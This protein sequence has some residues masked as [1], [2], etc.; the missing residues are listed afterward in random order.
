MSLRTF[1]YGGGHQ[2]TAGLILAA[3]GKIDYPVFLFANVG[4]DSEHPAT[5]DFVHNVA[6]PYAAA[7]GIELHE[8]HRERR[9]GSR[10]TLH[11]RPMPRKSACY[12]CPFHT[13]GTW[14]EMRRTEPDLFDKTV[15]LETLLNDRRA[16]LG[17]DSVYFNSR[18]VP[19]RQIPVAAEPMFEDAE[20]CDS[21]SCF[22]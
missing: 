1:S 19:L 13:I 22:T 15:E 9:D 16:A 4:D 12:F 7:H 11:G 20:T 10:E 21:F 5:L 2:S 6:M 14:A 3:Q 18:A 8:L 17:K